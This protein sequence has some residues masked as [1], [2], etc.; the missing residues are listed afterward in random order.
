M[1]YRKA[2]PAA[3]FLV[4]A[5]AWAQGIHLKSGAGR[6]TV[7]NRTRTTHVILQFPAY[8]GAALR[9]T[10]TR[11]GIRILQYVPDNALMVSANP[12]ADLSGLDV[13]W[14]GSL[15]VSDK[16]SPALAEQVSGPV[17]AVFY[18]DVP[19]QRARQLARAQGFDVIENPGLLAHQL[20]I[21]GPLARLPDLAAFDEVSYLLPASADLAAGKP[22]DGCAGAV[23]E[24]GPV[25]EYVLVGP[26]WPKDASGKVAL[27]YFIRN[28]TEK[29]DANVSRTEIERALAEWPKYAD[30]SLS[31]GQQGGSRTIDILFGSGAHGDPY[32]FDG[33]GGVL[34]HT[35]YPA[36]PNQEPIAGDMHLDADEGWHAG[37]SVDLFSVA[38]HEAGHALGLGHSDRPGSVMYPYY[39]QVTGLSDDDIAG[40]R[41]L[42]GAGT[43]TTATPPV[44]PPT[45]PVLPPTPPVQPP[46]PPVQPPVPNPPSGTDTTSPSLQISQSRIDHRVDHRTNHRRGRL[47]SRQR[48]SRQR[49][50]DGLHRQ[51]RDRLR[52]HCVECV[53][54][55]AG[56]HQRGDRA[57]LR[58]RG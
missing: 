58:C 29:L 9:D 33:P 20:V 54:A 36:P 21:S 48:G 28:L 44:L 51:F 25:G 15:N 41:A 19:P 30:F 26:G 23:T 56:R 43:T 16:I 32:P 57:R 3:L 45:P 35:F 17:L 38:L 46:N 55:A 10:L 37:S 4:A 42:Y 18:P 24:A 40:I 53:G 49:E 31:P 5:C 12:S 11:R 7:P 27:Q 1:N 13:V 8:P 2:V 14:A 47:G 52:Y 50:M 6:Q 22:V 39:R 34:A